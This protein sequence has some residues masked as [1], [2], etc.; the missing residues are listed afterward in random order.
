[1]GLVQPTDRE[2]SSAQQVFA[3]PQ[4][5]KREFSILSGHARLCSLLRE[6]FLDIFIVVTTLVTENLHHYVLSCRAIRKE[7]F[8]VNVR[9]RLGFHQ[10][11]QVGS[12]RGLLTRRLATL[13]RKLH[14][15]NTQ[16]NAANSSWP[17]PH[18][19]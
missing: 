2:C 13:R 1:M 10:F 7:D 8:P 11:E 18:G 16:E 3:R 4:P 6:R 12:D 5:C 17:A 15:S 14:G 19:D 9:N